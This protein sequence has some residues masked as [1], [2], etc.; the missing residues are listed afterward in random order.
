MATTTDTKALVRA[1][2]AWDDPDDGPTF[3]GWHDPSVRWNGFATPAFEK[4]EADKIMA[5]NTQA[6]AAG[7]GVERMTFDAATDAYLLLHPEAGEDGPERVPAFDARC[8]D[9]KWRRLYGVGSWAWTW[10][11]VLPRGH[12][13]CDTCGA[14]MEAHAPADGACPDGSGIFSGETFVAPIP[15]GELPADVLDALAVY[16]A[17]RGDAEAG[18][19]LLTT[20]ESWV[21]AGRPTKATFDLSAAEKASVLCGLQLLASHPPMTAGWGGT[22]ALDGLELEAFIRRL[23]PTWTVTGRV[24]A[25]V[26]TAQA[27][28]NPLELHQDD[29]I[30]MVDAEGVEWLDYDLGEDDSPAKGMVDGLT[31]AICGEVPE[32]GVFAQ[33][34]AEGHINPRVACMSHVLVVPSA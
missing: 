31:C 8:D 5:W 2:F 1:T 18:D 34:D 4:A 28:A 33:E 3:E 7:D 17:E 14:L 30:G 21:K 16:I 6:V 26:M 32:Q 13:L 24:G 12:T 29:A 25:A 15:A 11:E 19:Q 22:T 27:T 9:G 23:D 10:S 20:L